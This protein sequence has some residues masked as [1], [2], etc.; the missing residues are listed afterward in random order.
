MEKDDENPATWFYSCRIRE[1]ISRVFKADQISNIININ[2]MQKIRVPKKYLYH[3]PGTPETLTD[4]NY[5]IIAEKID[6]DTHGLAFINATKEQI[7]NFVT[8]MLE[9][10][11]TDNADGNIEMDKNGNLVLIDTDNIWFFMLKVNQ[12]TLPELCELSFYCAQKIKNIFLN[13]SQFNEIFR[14]FY[15]S[16]IEPILEKNY[17][18]LESLM[19]VINLYREISILG[20]IMTDINVYGNSMVIEEKK[21]IL[22]N[23]FQK[24]VD[25]IS[26]S[27]FLNEDSRYSL[28]QFFQEYLN[29]EE[30]F[31]N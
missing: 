8:I 5:L 23:I 31:R 4:E 28:N 17:E 6:L 20:A 30:N 2:G 7:S 13:I 27:Y 11:N 26:I 3:I 9:S 19:R 1:N 12:L 29:N 21:D 22:K 10:G 24:W 14:N 18:N 16:F 15:I 25:R